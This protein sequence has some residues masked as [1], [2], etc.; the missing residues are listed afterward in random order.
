VTCPKCGVENHDASRFCN[1][2]GASLAAPGGVT[3]PLPPVMPPAA[4]PVPGAAPPPPR[5][6]ILMGGLIAAVILLLIA[7]CAIGFL[8][9]SHGR[10]T[11]VAQTGTPSPS[12]AQTSTP[13]PGTDTPA[14]TP[15]P[16]ATTP[17]PAAVPPAKPSEEKKPEPPAPD[18]KP[19][20]KPPKPVPLEDPVAQAKVVLENYLA[21]DL[22]HDG[23]EMAKYLGGPAKAQFRADVQG[24][25]DITVHSKK[26]TGKTVRD[27]N[28]II[29]SVKVK[30]SP[31]GSSEVKSDTEKY[32]LKRTEVGWRIFST[33]AYPS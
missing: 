1:S 22:G 12:T 20:P 32:T 33:P 8:M 31:E 14:P 26:V 9:A 7:A 10:G 3:T 2:C 13:S 30:W 11:E 21:A 17:D 28:T 18:V 15:E 4:A 27:S 25:E 23:N 5:N 24:Q 16:D 19:V 6:N 29:F